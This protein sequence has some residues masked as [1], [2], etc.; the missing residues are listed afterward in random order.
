MQN[1][2]G[3]AFS[4]IYDST[5]SFLAAI[6]EIEQVA[7]IQRF[8]DAPLRVR[9]LTPYE[10]KDSS[11]FDYA[12]TTLDTFR[13]DEIYVTVS[14]AWAHSQSTTGLQIP[15]YRI[16]DLS[17]PSE[18]PRPPR[19]PSVIFHRAAQYART[20]GYAYLW[21]DQ[22]YIYQRDEADRERHLQVMHRIYSASAVTIAALSVH[23]PDAL[24]LEEFI[25]WA[26][27]EREPRETTRTLPTGTLADWLLAM[28]SDAWFTRTWT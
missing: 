3:R 11:T 9:L 13:G 4:E 21:I 25:G 2:T 7:L 16:W 23:M 10:S 27:N 5:E 26:L 14:Y 24:V 28:T 20:K 6:E 17:Q 8:D 19:C 18:P 1:D 22:E 12:I 15:S